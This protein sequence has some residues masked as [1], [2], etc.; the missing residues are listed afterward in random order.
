MHG[1]LERRVGFRQS[2]GR[3]LYFS[4]VFMSWVRWVAGT[5]FGNLL[6]SPEP[7][8]RRVG[9]LWREKDPDSFLLVFPSPW[10]KF[11]LT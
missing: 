9:I 8:C 4:C 6:L 5:T 10:Q 2:L 7:L 3:E 1:L 11:V